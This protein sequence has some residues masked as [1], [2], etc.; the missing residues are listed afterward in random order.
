VRNLTVIVAV[1]AV[2]GLAT[3]QQMGISGT[4]IDA[5][6]RAPIF[7]AAVHAQHGGTVHTDSAGEYFIEVVR[8]G[9]YVVAAGAPGYEPQVYPDTVFVE[10]GQ[11]VENID[12]ALVPCQPR[13]FGAISGMVVDAQT[14]EPIARARVHT[15]HRLEAYTN[16]RGYYVIDSVP[17]GDYIVG[18]TAEGYRGATYPD[19]VTVVAGQTTENIDFA[20]VP[21]QPREFGAIAGT[22]TDAGTG[23]PIEGAR[24]HTSTVAKRSQTRTVST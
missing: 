19:S 10:Q 17:A 16:E 20:L 23:N 6:T 24:V 18:A 8:P 22:V 13:E 12:F 15:M 5:E 2:V 1:L 3:A 4:V 7:H 14:R 21:C 11:V 9:P